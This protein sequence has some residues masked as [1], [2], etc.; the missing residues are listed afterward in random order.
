ML[1]LHLKIKS[2]SS[3][4][5]TPLSPPVMALVT[6]SDSEDSEIE[7]ANLGEHNETHAK[8]PTRKSTFQKVVDR[9]EPHK[10]RISLPGQGNMTDA[11]SRRDPSQDDRP[12]K[13]TKTS[14]G[15]GGFNALLPAPKNTLKNKSGT[16]GV[17]K[18]KS[19][20][21][22]ALGLGTG[23]NLKTGAAPAFAREEAKEA[24]VASQV[25]SEESTTWSSNP[26]SGIAVDEAQVKLIGRPAMF[27]P[28]SVSRKPT[29]T[30]RPAHPA[31]PSVT[32][33]NSDSKVSKASPNGGEKSNDKV[34]EPPKSLSLFSTGLELLED[35]AASK[36]T[37]EPL[38]EQEN[39][40]KL[41][42]GA[43]ESD[44]GVEKVCHPE[45]GGPQDPPKLSD[46]ADTLGLS[47]SERRRLF[48]RGGKPSDAQIAQFSLK[49]EY[50]HNL[51]QNEIQ[52]ATPA[53]N[54]VKSIAPGK[55]SLQQLMNAAS[56]QKD[57][58]EEQ[59]ASGRRNKKD[60]GSKYGF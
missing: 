3:P 24:N 39:S 28:L 9:S 42:T 47:A 54:P 25:P 40:N 59:W 48:G 56:N 29:R 1:S 37:L 53:H 44:K 4:S 18:P 38:S 46:L 30:K 2:G 20:L 43:E 11:T 22:Q 36:E 23:V 31:S 34:V 50:A 12:T 17:G 27:K 55:H 49:A 10:I 13:R 14:G 58:L 7:Q 6:Y 21:K 8:L 32:A 51:E 41:L 52:G 15:L 19:S 35:T 45:T 33:D 57:A 16:E 26:V 5:T 60:A